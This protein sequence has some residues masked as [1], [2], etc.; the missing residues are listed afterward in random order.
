MPT[1]LNPKLTDA[2]KAA[3]INA[4]NNGLQLAITHVSLG[5]GKYDSATTGASKTAMVARKES[6]VIAQGV[7]TGAGGF[8]I[9]IRFPAW[10]GTPSPYDATELAFFAGDPAA[11]GVLV[12]VYSHPTDVLVQRSATIDYVASFNFQITEVPSGSITVVTDPT[13]AQAL[14][15]IGLHENATNPH[16]QYVRKSGDLSTG[17]QR[18]PHAAVNDDSDAYA[19]TGFVKRSGKTYPAHGGIGLSNGQTILPG[20]VGSWFSPSNGATVY[21]PLASSVPIGSTL[22]FAVSVPSAFINAQA[23]EIIYGAGLVAGQRQLLVLGETVEVTRNEAGAWLVTGIGA[24]MPAGAVMHF[25]GQTPPAGWMPMSGAL[26]ERAAYPALWAYAQSQGLVS[27][28]DWMAGYFGR[29]SV[30]TNGGNFRI[31]D[32]RGVFLRSLDGGRGIDPN[33]PWGMYQDQVNV[34]HAH[35]VYDPGHA[36]SVYDPGHV[37]GVNDPTHAHGVTVNAAGDHGHRLGIQPT[38]EGGSGDPWGS[39]GPNRPEGGIYSAY[40]DAAGN[41]AHS[42]YAHGAYTGIWLAAAVSQTAIYAAGTGI[43]I[44]AEGGADGHPRNLAYVLAIRF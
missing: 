10:T 21:L 34:A 9:N 6:V 20:H 14:V 41:H 37:H 23:G 27:E 17:F 42:A 16:T 43:S 2:G 26:V 25:A 39:G 7:V 13:A 4:K 19:T 28:A 29:F 32:A 44:A 36:H 11:G 12:W 3:A 33:R 1:T 40:T 8:R 35:G 30:G 5:T 22:K 31:P 24:R 18:G 15:L 38:N